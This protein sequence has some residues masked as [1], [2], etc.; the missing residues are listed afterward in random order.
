MHTDSIGSDIV[1]N[2]D[3]YPYDEN[4]W[5]FKPWIMT[6]RQWDLSVAEDVYQCIDENTD[7]NQ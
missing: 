7:K 2:I 1:S 5:L 4:I 3:S 6:Y